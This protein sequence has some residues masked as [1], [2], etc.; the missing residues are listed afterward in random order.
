MAF[1]KGNKLAAK[2]KKFQ[3]ELEKALAQGDPDQL[4]R[5]AEKLLAKAEEGDLFAIREVADRL[6]GKATQTVHGL[7]EHTVHVGDGSSIA[8]KLDRSLASRTRPTVQ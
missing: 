7:L 1:E 6:D 5:I 4:R 3:H 8:P 2:G